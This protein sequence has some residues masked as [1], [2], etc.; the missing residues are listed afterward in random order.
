VHIDLCTSQ[1]SEYLHLAIL[2]QYVKL[3]TTGSRG[4]CPSGQSTIADCYQAIGNGEREEV[5]KVLARA[6]T[7]LL[8]WWE[9]DLPV[10]FPGTH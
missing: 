6:L 4:Y 3:T 1:V 7:V 9:E 8:T 10:L 2:T 5:L